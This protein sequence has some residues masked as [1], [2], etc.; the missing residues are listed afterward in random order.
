[1]KGDLESLSVAEMMHA[2]EY[3]DKAASEQN[4]SAISESSFT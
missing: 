3:C 1:M 4:I 2:T